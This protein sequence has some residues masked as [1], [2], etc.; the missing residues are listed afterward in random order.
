MELTRYLPESTVAGAD[1]LL[2]RGYGF[3]PRTAAF[4]GLL[5]G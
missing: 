5:A 2:K 3:H 4:A 1:R